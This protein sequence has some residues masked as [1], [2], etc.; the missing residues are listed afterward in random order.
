M[1]KRLLN[2]LLSAL[3]VASISVPAVLA[4]DDP[5]VDE[6]LA[7]AAETIQET[8]SMSF[9]MV[10][11]GTTYVDADQNIQLLGAEGVMQRPDRADVIFTAVFLGM[12]QISIR[13]ITIDEDAWIT[14]I[15]TGKW[16]PAPPEFGYNP[17][18]L[19]D[20]DHG[21]GPVMG[22]MNDPEVVGSE[23]IDGKDAWHIVATVDGE[24]THEMTSGTMRGSV[25]TLDLWIDKDTSDILQ[26]RIS[27]P[28]DEDLEDPA[29]WTLI[30]TDHNEEVNIEQPGD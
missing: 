21:L 29:T 1:R 7:A 5:T 17:S 16:V 10:M 11:E 30:L 18:V 22:R 3:I 26:I 4:E 8:E 23:E 15:V 6:I 2:V 27:E 19:Y 28:E 14:D 13:M 20:D 24:V 25:Q 12:Q 9:E